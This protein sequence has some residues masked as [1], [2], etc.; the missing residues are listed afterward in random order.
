MELQ[1]PYS[2][3]PEVSAASHIRED[4]SR[5]GKDILSDEQVKVIG[6][7]FLDVEEMKLIQTAFLMGM[8]VDEVKRVTSCSYKGNL[9][10]EVYKY[11]AERLECIISQITS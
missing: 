9:K 2:I 10:N 1:V 11:G 6:N 4:K 7:Q 5:C 3:C 8:S